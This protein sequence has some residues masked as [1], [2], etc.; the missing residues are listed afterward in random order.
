MIVVVAVAVVGEVSA[1]VVV[2]PS[3]PEVSCSGSVDSGTDYGPSSEEACCGNL[4]SYSPGDPW[5]AGRYQPFDVAAVACQGD[6]TSFAYLA[7]L[8]DPPCTCLDACHTVAPSFQD[9]YLA[10][11]S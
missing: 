10:L 11:N 3:Y 8:Q 2:D 1:A 5:V 9:A 4:A 6:Q 7:D